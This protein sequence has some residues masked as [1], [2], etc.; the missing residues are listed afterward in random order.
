MFSFSHALTFGW[1]MFAK[2]WKTDVKIPDR[3]DQS[4]IFT[5]EITLNENFKPPPIPNLVNGDALA[6]TTS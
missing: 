5:G 4:G 6:E 1:A 3:T 2:S